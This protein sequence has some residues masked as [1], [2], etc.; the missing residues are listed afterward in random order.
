MAQADGDSVISTTVLLS[1][2]N[3][4]GE[5]RDLVRQGLATNGIRMHELQDFRRFISLRR[6]VRM[7]EWLAAELD[8]PALGLRLAQRSGPDALGAVGYLFLSSGDLETKLQS[9][10]R[11]LEAIQSSSTTDIS[12]VGD[13]LQ[14]SYRIVDDSITPRAQ[15][16]EY[17]IG[18]I[19]RYMRLLSKNQCSLTQVTFEHAQPA[20]AGSI[21][22]RVFGAPV[23]FD[24]G[25]NELTLPLAEARRWYEGLDPHLIPILEDH[26][27]STMRNAGTPLAFHETVT[28]ALTDGV[29]RQ[30]ARA[31]LVASTLGVSTATLFRRLRVEKRQF[32]DLVTQRCKDIAARLLRDSSVT[33]G[34][35]S[36]R[37]GYAEPAA[38]CRAFRRWFGTTPREFRRQVRLQNG[39]GYNA[40]AARSAA[41]LETNA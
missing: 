19:W 25:A 8:D 32:K 26:I 12:Y 22:R 15:D 29:L 2:Y 20:A 35:L 34:E 37:L 6:F 39:D 33:V 16:S 21:H 18:L 4:L 13:Y 9:L 31:E 27:S 41:T 7:F 38:F 3:D 1:I 30:G 5:H 23:L 14:V 28:Q 36:A 10:Q 11:Y 24:Q 17:S 40:A